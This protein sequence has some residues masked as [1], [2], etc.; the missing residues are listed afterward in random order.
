M[1]RGTSLALRF[2]EL[3]FD[4][5]LEAGCALATLRLPEDPGIAGHPET[6]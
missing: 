1:I 3:S 6:G 4:L 2:V 5:S